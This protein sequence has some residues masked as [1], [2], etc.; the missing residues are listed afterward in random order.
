MLDKQPAPF[1][2]KDFAK[3]VGDL[4]EDAAKGGGGRISLT[5]AREGSVT[6]TLLEVFAR[7]LAVVYEQLDSVYQNAYLDTAQGAALD[8][9][10]WLLGIKRRQPG[11]L[12]GRVSFARSLPAPEDIYI[13]A[14]TLVAGKDVL[15]C[16][17]L[18]DATLSHGELVV[19]VEIQ[20][21]EPAQEEDAIPAQS[22]KI[23]PRPITGIERVYNE[24]ALVKRQQGEDDE[25]LRKRSHHA[26]HSVQSGTVAAL[27]QSVRALGIEQ[28]K[29]L[30]YPDEPSLAPGRI[31]VVVGDENLSDET[32][33]HIRQRIQQVRPA[34]ILVEASKTRHFYIDLAAV[35]TLEGNFSSLQKQ[36][37]EMD[38]IGK[39]KQY[40]SQITTGM[41]IRQEK[42]RSILLG[43]QAVAAC[44]S[45]DNNNFLMKVYSLGENTPNISWQDNTPLY[46]N[47]SG[48]IMIPSDG[49]AVLSIDKRPIRLLM[50]GPEPIV[51]LDI[52]FEIKNDLKKS[53]NR[54]EAKEKITANFINLINDLIN[55]KK[56]KIY[57]VNA[58][59]FWNKKNDANDFEEDDIVQLTITVVHE[60]TGKVVELIVNEQKLASEFDKNN[61]KEP[62]QLRE[63]LQLRSVVIIEREADNSTS[64]AGN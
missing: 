35:L 43:H 59:E 22:L 29:I 20:S 42:I 31:K 51:Y 25:A 36:A 55:N 53:L 24:L 44:E 17:T 33:A 63:V 15:L 45:L 57:H 30:E 4:L 60:N 41:P 18:Q 58:E 52:A 32:M 39:I 56:D 10:I 23:M 26:L 2:K 37:I 27:E 5:D 3:L 9:V 47:G 48:D 62:L 19:Q 28:V 49:C 1:I 11:H 13:P 12:E 38:L 14:G 7:E 61:F 40:F 64:V 46:R 6:R 16:A 54:A 50:Q 21:L 34:G 8:K